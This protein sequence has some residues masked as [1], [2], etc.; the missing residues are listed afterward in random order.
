MKKIAFILFF[1]TL[2]LALPAYEGNVIQITAR[3]SSVLSISMDTPSEFSII[4]SDGDLIPSKAI[5]EILVK[6]SY[7]TW[8]MTIDS[9]YES[10][11]TV[12]RLKRDDGE[13]YIPYTF[14]IRDGEAV[15]LNQF[16]V[17]SASNLPTP[18]SGKK[19]NV[20]FFF[21]DDGTKWP[22]GIYRDTLVLSVTSD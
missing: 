6:S 10:S 4:D 12:G 7:S 9:L 1:A 21:A 13:D 19:F 5:G 2:I 3:V 11:G 8:K 14:Q 16:N 22:Q 20:V 18:F 17:R 15:L